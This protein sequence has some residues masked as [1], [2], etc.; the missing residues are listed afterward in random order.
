MSALLSRLLGLGGLVLIVV[1]VQLA[2]R[3][4]FAAGVAVPAPGAAA[5][6][7]RF[8]CDEPAPRPSSDA[9]PIERDLRPRGTERVIPVVVHLMRTL[10]CAADEPCRVRC[11][12][13]TPSC[14]WTPAT[15]AEHFSS[16]GR[17]N[18]IWKRAGIR[19]AVVAVR[20][21]AYDPVK[22]EQLPDSLA[23][24]IPPPTRDAALWAVVGGRGWRFNQVNLRFGVDGALN[25]F[26]WIRAEGD[27]VNSITYFGSSPRHLRVLEPKRSIVWADAFCVWQDPDRPEAQKFTPPECA[28]KLA[29]EVGHAL[30]LR[31]IDEPGAQGA[32]STTE[33]AACRGLGVV[34]GVA[35]NLMRESPGVPKN[36]IPQ[37]V[38]LTAWQRCQARS[39]AATF[40]DPRR[41]TDR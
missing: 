32:D 25:L 39:A 15:L 33:F 13:N 3:P 8:P 23:P 21:C 4:A 22:F 7:E 18:E 2:H 17:V 5:A 30:T 20:E 35:R 24:G 29:H 16:S 6:R 1:G 31:H 41:F 14:L 10:A 26:L 28:R 36:Q 27:T 12:T 9:W 37:H 38:Q 34:D 11:P 19:L 40:F